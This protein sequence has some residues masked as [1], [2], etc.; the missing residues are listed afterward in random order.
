MRSKPSRIGRLAVYTVAVIASFGGNVLALP[1]SGRNPDLF[2]PALSTLGA[3][4]LVAGFLG[5]GA[6]RILKSRRNK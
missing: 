5:M 6:Y 4:G 1:L 3:V 2:V